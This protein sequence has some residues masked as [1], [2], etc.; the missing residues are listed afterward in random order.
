ML[1]LILASQSPRR[2]TI[3]S[4]A[5][6]KYIDLPVNVSEI[7]DKNLN[8]DEQI[9][10]IAQ[11]KAFACLELNKHLKN[12]DFLILSAD[13]MV[14]IDQDT[15]G[16]PQ[17]F[18]EAKTFLQRLSGRSHLVKTGLFLINC[19]TLEQAMSLETTEV[20]FRK[21]SEKEIEDYIQ[22]GEP[23]DKAGAYGIQ[24][25]GR[26]FVVRI[27][28]QLDNVIGLPMQTFKDLLEKTQWQVNSG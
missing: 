8:L 11:D 6:F 28:G 5:G 27:E 2:K 15:L 26:A 3:L 16:K 23:M 24:S 9:L 20:F 19:R 14:I 7:P 12:Q 13:T 18:N 25:L 22:T 10:K 4:E 1:K 21:L 17:D